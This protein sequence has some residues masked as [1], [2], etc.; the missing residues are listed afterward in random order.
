MN[1]SIKLAIFYIF[2]LFTSLPAFAQQY[3]FFDVND[4][5]S[6]SNI[7]SITQD[8]EGFLWI[9]TEDGLNRFDGNNF[10]VYRNIPNDSLSLINNHVTKIQEDRQGRFW[11]ATL[12]GLCLYDRV[13][14][15]FTQFSVPDNNEKKENTQFYNLIEDHNGYIWVCVSGNGVVRIDADKNEFLSFNTSNS[16]ICSDHI[17][18]IHE[19]RFGNIWLGSGQEGV[20]VYN[21]ANG[22]FRTYRYNP[23][24]KT[25]LSSNEIS[26]ICEDAEGNIW[27]GTWVEGINIYSFT[28]QS[29][30]LFE[31]ATSTI[32]SLNKDSK[33]NIWIGMMEKGVDVYSTAEK[34][35]ID[36]DIQSMSV[37]ISSKVEAIFE[38]SQGNMWIGFYQ[39]GLFM[40]PNEEA[41]FTNY[42]FNPFSKKP[43]IGDGAVQPVFLDSTN[44]LWVGVDGKGIY[45]LDKDKNIIAHYPMSARG[46]QL[47]NNVV[48]CICE[49]SEQN[50]WLGTFFD[51][52]IRYNRKSDHFDKR[53]T[54]KGE[55]GLLSSQVN[56][57]MESRDGKLY[58][59]TNGGGINIYDPRTESF[60]YLVRDGNNPD[61]N[62]LIDN[63]CS[64]IYQD[65]RD[66]FWFGTFRGLCSYDKSNNLFTH[67]SLA[68]KKLPNDIIN[69][70]KE[71]VRGNLWIGTQ[72]GLVRIDDKREN[73]TCYNTPNG[74]PNSMILGIQDDKEDNLWIITNSGIA[75][76]DTKKQSFTNYTTSDGLFTN[77]FKKNAITKSPDGNL[78]VGSMRG[79]TSFHPSRKKPV[80]AEPLNLLF[81]NL[82]IFN[83]RV[84][85]GNSEKGELEKSIN[86]LDE[87]T[88]TND[89]NSFSIDFSAI[90]FMSPDKVTYEVL[91]YGF[92]K[93][94]QIA[95]NRMVTYTNLSSGEYTLHVRAWINDKSK[96]LEKVLKIKTLPPFW[97][98][99]LAKVLYLVLFL[100]ISY[101]IYRYINER[102][103]IKRQEQF[104]QAKLQF[105]TDI[106]HEIRTPL[107]LIL[108]PLNKLINKNKDL[109]LTSTYNL[110]YKN[111]I[112]LLQLVNEVMD[113]RAVEFGKKKLHVEETNVTVFVRELKNSFNNLAEEKNIEFSFLSEPEEIIGYIDTD[114]ISKVLFNLLSNAF[115]YTD[116]GFVRVTLQ[117]E[118]NKLVISITDSGKGIP[119]DQKELIFERFYMITTN[120]E[121]RKKSS[122]IGLH[123]T[124]RLI[125]LHHGEILL[126]SENGVGSCFSVVIPFN[127][128]DYSK[129]ELIERR[130]VSTDVKVF[131]QAESMT[132]RKKINSGKYKY[133]LLIVEDHQDIRNLI[134]GELGGNFR[135]LEASDGEEGLRMALEHNPSLIIS[136]VLMPKMDGIELCDKIR[137][138]ERTAH[139]PFI[140]LTA[141]SSVKQQIEGLEHGADAY[142][143]K[144]FNMDYLQAQIDR[145]L[146][147]KD[148]YIKKI[149]SEKENIVEVET[150][151]TILLRKLSN[152]I[153]EHL[154]NTELSVDVLCKEIGLSRTH[155]N[156]KMKELT[157]D[158]PASYIRQIR[159]RKSTQLLKE[160]NLTISE[161]AFKVGFSS[162]S[163][164]SQA[165]RDY[166]GVTPK[167]YLQTSD[168]L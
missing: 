47:N 27:I 18:V 151:D 113:L 120:S 37:D 67:Y 26:S 23:G 56:Y 46:S 145:L 21:P 108:S 25:G 157:G 140:M 49:D 60:E 32:S 110:M 51:G 139:I 30:E 133:T 61:P 69:F 87:I 158:S 36:L 166:Y 58:I 138:N 35:M 102:I 19:D 10:K 54:K 160:G 93:Q 42:G 107:T 84:P 33:D 13:M 101:L 2:L 48:L 90:E 28:K 98:T 104:I 39:R 127:K 161:I 9:A 95:K 148:R 79:I 106:S 97:A 74:L 116:K 77:E 125:K 153:D 152:I 132:V 124:N 52:I 1:L 163:Y 123:L 44:E 126:S 8:R 17:N 168:S 162:P 14:D 20:S 62:Q 115:K 66:V 72:N 91:M 76:Y 154:D 96:P 156:R 99:N 5:L 22:H 38:D 136:D 150:N 88:F 149:K 159:L 105:F 55:K 50:I 121:E 167:E 4:G 70:L 83:N 122:G 131:M 63:Y 15:R 94:W 143:A 78:I 119:D 41:F 147:N 165:F 134:A 128:S 71:D 89:Q 40:I 75:M 12:K 45:R 112:R 16:G 118:K 100:G 7:T 111:G 114:I 146:A 73:I 85:I 135:I 92:D 80:Q 43:T 164:F 137:R 11:I 59:A 82:Y 142:I 6:S 109:S 34:K 68:N 86:Y 129:E 103:T 155:L 31:Y 3:K 64:F 29:F 144:P 65:H 117:T 81:G 57:I 24:D 53:L 130:E 141:R